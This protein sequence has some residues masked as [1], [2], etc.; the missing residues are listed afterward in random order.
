MTVG[1]E[2][3]AGAFGTVVRADLKRNDKNIPCAV[4]MLKSTCK[5]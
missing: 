4:K 2:L 3:G 5:C 1:K